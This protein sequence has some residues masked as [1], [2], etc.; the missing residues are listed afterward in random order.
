MDTEN[1]NILML[2]HNTTHVNT[3]VSIFTGYTWDNAS[4]TAGFQK[5][6]LDTEADDKGELVQCVNP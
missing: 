3:D 1:G 6:I 5:C 4:T 2:R